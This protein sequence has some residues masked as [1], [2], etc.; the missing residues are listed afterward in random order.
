MLRVKDKKEDLEGKGWGLGAGSWTGDVAQLVECLPSIHKALGSI[1]S[2]ANTGSN[3][4]A[5]WPCTWEVEAGGAEVRE[6]PKLHSQFEPNLIHEA[7]SKKQKKRNLFG[8]L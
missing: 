3:Y 6:Y 2:M 4:Q 5:C 1:P 7:L 8:T